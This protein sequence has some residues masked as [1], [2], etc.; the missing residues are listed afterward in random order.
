[1]ITAAERNG[2]GVQEKNKGK[3]GKDSPLTETSFYIL[4]SLKEERHGY[5]II[6]WIRAFTD[7]EVELQGGTVY[8]CLLRM[9]QEGLIQMT[10]ED[11]RRKYYRLTRQGEQALAQEQLRLDRLRQNSLGVPWKRI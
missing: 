7:G 6:Q 5:D 3:N 2:F 11:S 10:S 4:L 8:N 9:E 1:M